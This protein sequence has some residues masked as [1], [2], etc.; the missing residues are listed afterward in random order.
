M[1][2]TAAFLVGIVLILA[3]GLMLSET[4]PTVAQTSPE[5]IALVTASTKPSP[6]ATTKPSPTATPKLG[7][8]CTPGFW[9][10]HT[11][12]WPSAYSPSQ[13]VG[14]VFTVPSALSSLGSAT[15]LQAL[16]FGGGAGAIGGARTLLRDAVAA[17]L[18]SAA[19]SGYPVTTSNVISMTNAAL[20]SGDRSTMLS[21]A[22]NFNA[23]NN[24]GCP[25]N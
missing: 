25:V 1:T 24:L 19:L 16:D 9:K 5:I 2:K 4:G 6:T 8:G 15:L 14:S 21:L 22:S 7:Q 13:T 17:L 10:N 12:A 3:L 11:S 18:N 20:A 23:S